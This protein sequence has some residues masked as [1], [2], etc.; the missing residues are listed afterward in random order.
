MSD[1]RFQEAAYVVNV[2]DRNLLCRIESFNNYSDAL[3]CFNRTVAMGSFGR[4]QDVYLEGIDRAGQFI[5]L[6]Q[7]HHFGLD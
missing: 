3:N 4:W 5:D 7:V 1:S 2:K 6:Y